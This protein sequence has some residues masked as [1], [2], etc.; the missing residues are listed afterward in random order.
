MIMTKRPKL[1]ILE[2]E[3]VNEVI[4]QAKD[5][6][7][8][9]GV[10]VEN[11]EGLDLFAKEGISVNDRGRILIPADLIDKCLSYAPTSIKLYDREGNLDRKS[12]V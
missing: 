11:Q 2:D 10:I 5:I 9:L 3:L 4:V 7:E 6:L 12:V 1:K 8:T